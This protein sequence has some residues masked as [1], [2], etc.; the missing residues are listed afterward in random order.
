MKY[1]TLF[2]DLVPNGILPFSIEDETYK[3]IWRDIITSEKELLPFY[4]LKMNEC[5]NAFL[6]YRRSLSDREEKKA[7]VA[8]ITKNLISAYERASIMADKKIS[9]GND[10]IMGIRDELMCLLMLVTRAFIRRNIDDNIYYDQSFIDSLCPK[11]TDSFTISLEEQVSGSRAMIKYETDLSKKI[12]SELSEYIFELQK[13]KNVNCLSNS[14]STMTWNGQN[15]TLTDM[16]RQAKN[17]KY[18]NN[19]IPEIASFLKQHFTC[20]SETKLSTIENMLKNNNSS[21]NSRPKSEKII[22][23]E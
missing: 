3:L 2:T 20:F 16:F 10:E 14:P 1:F 9:A 5:M 4:P 11:P 8:S 17:K 15:N 12:L 13:S 23:I 6:E 7:F 22:N 21:A 18:L 19:T